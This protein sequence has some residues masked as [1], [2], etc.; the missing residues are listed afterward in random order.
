MRAVLA[1]CVLL[2]VGCTANGPIVRPA[3]SQSPASSVPQP[4]AAAS[5]GVVEYPVSAASFPGRTCQDCDRMSLSG[6]TT[7]RDG[8]VWFFDV[9]QKT[10]GRVTP[11]GVITQY[12][13]PATGSGSRSIVGAPDG[14]IWMVGRA[15]AND[16]DLILRVS[17]NGDV[18]K[19]PI[20]VGVTPESITWGPDG[21]IWFT[22]FT[23]G[24]IARM[25]PAGAVTE[26]PG[27]FASRGIV[28][29][30]DHNL[31]F[32]ASGGS[33]I[34]RMTTAGELTLYPLG[35]SATDQR[36]PT[37]IVSGTDG[38]LWFTEIGKIGR[39]TTSGVVTHFALPP[40]SHSF[41][42]AFGP[43][44][45]LWFTDSVANAIVRMSPTGV[46][47]QFALPRRNSQPLGIAAGADGRMWFTEAGWF[48]GNSRIGSIGITVPEV[49]LSSRVLTFN[50]GSAPNWRAVEITNTGEAD[51]KISS[52]NIVG[53]DRDA[54]ETTKETCVGRSVTVNASCQIGVSFTAG[55]DQGVIG[56]RLAITDN[57]T[58]TPHMVSL[59]AQLPDCKLPL[60]ASSDSSAPSQGEFLNLRNGELVED[61]AGRF[62]TD[63][64]LFQLQGTPVLKGQLP[65]TYLWAAKRW[66]PA[67][68]NAISPDGSRYVYFDYQQGMDRVLHVVDIATG[69]D[70]TLQLPRGFW[71]PIGFTNDGIYLHQA[72]EGIG[73]G[74]TLVNPDSGA[75]RTVF[76]DSAVHW[77]SGQTAW[78]ATRNE[79]DTLPQP[80]GIGGSNNEV[81]SRDFV[82]LQKTSW[83]YRPGSNLYVAAAAKGSIVVTVYTADSNSLLIV[84]APG[85]AVPIT[86]PGTDEPIPLGGALVS[87]DAT[88]WWLGSLDGLYLWTPHTGA[89]LVSEATAT[90]AGACA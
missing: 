32:A 7:G 37:E 50:R 82:S 24:R 62:V 15:Q 20:G 42:L 88:S 3:S 13:V 18:T 63:G 19:Y 65:A 2:A 57:A 64:T 61:P 68:D 51:L 77:I 29:G 12:A 36:E 60:F 47:R 54:F 49:K 27:G 86:I 34:G 75:V 8:N 4:H 73:P 56:A 26:F 81:Q 11:A 90:P 72:Y 45:N 10:V 1:V 25:T 84:N 48:A 78:I 74:L 87:A 21:N 53:P 35:G 52:I 80:P 70:R 89:I 85:Q 38:N 33:A 59:V 71:S 22:E 40:R 41:G 23:S 17:P 66:V 14:N 43:D 83:L 69:R 79:T 39:I 31:W 28:T 9:G 67:R 30:P 16:P 55:S 6:I 76:S 58:G 44:R 5:G 46:M